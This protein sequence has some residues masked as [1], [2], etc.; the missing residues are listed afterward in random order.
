[1]MVMALNDNVCDQELG[2]LSFQFVEEENK[3]EKG[4]GRPRAIKERR[5]NEK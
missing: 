2:F 4:N 3:I 5:T 1:M